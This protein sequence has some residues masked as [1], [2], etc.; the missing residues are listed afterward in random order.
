MV[1]GKIKPETYEEWNRETGRKEL[2]G[3]AERAAALLDRSEAHIRTFPRMGPGGYGMKDVEIH[4]LRGDT[5]KALAS[6]REVQR[7]RWRAWW[8]YDRDWNPHFD[9]IRNEP[10]FKAVFANIERDMAKQRTALAERPK[11]APLDLTATGT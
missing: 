9:S 8:G 7:A 5:I 2:P 11:D 6:L 10:E 3:E 4:V 1:E